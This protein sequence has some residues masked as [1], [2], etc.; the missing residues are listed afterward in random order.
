MFPLFTSTSL[1]LA[2]TAL[3]ACTAALT[4][5][6]GPPRRWRAALLV[7]VGALWVLPLAAMVGPDPY[8]INAA[9]LAGA[10]T[11]GALLA[12]LVWGVL[13][14]RVAGGLPAV[15]VAL[16]PGLA[17][18]AYLL[19]RQRVP[20]APCASEVVFRIGD[21]EL[22]L[23]RRFGL[24]SE[25][26]IGAPA[27]DWEG[28]YSEWPGAK[29]H[30]R[31]LC[32]ATDGGTR[33]IEVSH[34]WLRF[35]PFRRDLEAECDSGAAL[36][37]RPHVCEALARVQPTIVQFYSNLQGMALPSF[38]QFNADSILQARADGNLEGYRCND[39]TR[40]PEQRHCVIWHEVTPDVF[41]VSSAWA[42]PYRVDEDLRADSAILLEEL[43]LR[44]SKD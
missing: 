31:A 5:L 17:V 37:S 28:A 32:R 41:A 3:S 42:G 21:L 1:L 18:S 33:P 24:R 16:F 38:G 9:L 22:T 36:S 2:V 7:A 6:R 43:R 27:Q 44:I 14:R 34:I 11:S 29:S 13:A 15:L 20:Q 25:R 35:S 23:P 40:G 39:S 12:G 4:A 30:V 19:E 26:P 10:W 8:T